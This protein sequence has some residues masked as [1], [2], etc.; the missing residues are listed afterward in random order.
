MDYPALPWISPRTVVRTVNY[1]GLPYVL[2]ITLQTVHYHGL[3][4]VLVDYP[5]WKSVKS[6]VSYLDDLDV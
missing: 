1:Q 4:Y 3:P 5:T 6:L 2:W